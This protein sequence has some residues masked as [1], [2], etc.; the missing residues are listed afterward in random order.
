MAQDVLRLE[1][2]PEEAFGRRLQ[3]A[4]LSVAYTSPYD[5]RVRMYHDR[6]YA[7]FNSKEEYVDVVR[8]ALSLIV[9]ALRYD[10]RSSAGCSVP[11]V[12]GID[13]CTLDRGPSLYTSGASDLK[14]LSKAGL[15]ACPYITSQGKQSVSW[16]HAAVSYAV[17]VIE[18][19]GPIGGSGVYEIPSLA[20]VTVFSNVRGA[21][22]KKEAK[23]IKAGL[24]ELG[25][26]LLGGALSYLGSH[27]LSEK[28]GERL[29]FL[30]VP[31][32]P[33]YEFKVFRNIASTDGISGNLAARAAALVSE[34]G[35][36]VEQAFSLAVAIL[37]GRH[38]ELLRGLGSEDRVV[39]SAR[40]Y[41]VSSGQRPMLRGGLPLSTIIYRTYSRELLNALNGTVWYARRVRGGKA[42]EALGSALREC[43]SGLFLQASAPCHTGFL[44][45]CGRLLGQV[46]FDDEMPSEARSRASRLLGM[47]SREYERLAR[48]CL[49]VVV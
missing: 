48:E 19:G 18:N 40:L 20:K 7:D 10:R 46:A 1:L 32:R 6:G 11:P 23:T 30:L 3:Y 24:D 9:K 27:R 39:G 2:L 38:Q 47:V 14:T 41:T 13:C 26:V 37:L 25:T 34:L 36:G 16:V 29:E 8:E 44:A 4:F 35:V 42:H 33:S 15:T 5:S 31:D 17:R 49:R 28:G 43:I 21:R 22:V 45:D 12:G